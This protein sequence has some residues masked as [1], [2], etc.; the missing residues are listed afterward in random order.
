MV[1]GMSLFSISILIKHIVGLSVCLL[2][3][4]NI[5]RLKS[6]HHETRHV[7]PKKFWPKVQF[8]GHC[9]FFLYYLSQHLKNQHVSSL[10]HSLTGE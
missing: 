9:N 6:E 3:T 10:A 2:V 4:S 8:L 1:N 5:L 7:G